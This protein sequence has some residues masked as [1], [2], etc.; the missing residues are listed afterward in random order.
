MQKP[1]KLG[2]LPQEIKQLVSVTIKE[3]NI[4]PTDSAIPHYWQTKTANDLFIA[5]HID[6]TNNPVY[7]IRRK[8]LDPIAII[9]DKIMDSNGDEI[10]QENRLLNIKNL[11]LSVRNC[12]YR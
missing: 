12:L 1:E 3:Q 11:I 10:T 6:H 9:S 5:C 7:S 4:V 8:D 2:S